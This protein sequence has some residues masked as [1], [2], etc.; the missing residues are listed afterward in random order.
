MTEQ[1]IIERLKELVEMG[2]SRRKIEM[3]L[4]MPINQLSGVM[5]GK[6]TFPAK[7]KSKLEFYITAARFA[8]DGFREQIEAVLNVPGIAETK[9]EAIS[10][11]IDKGVAIV[12]TTEEKTERIDP[13]SHQGEEIIDQARQ[14]QSKSFRTSKELDHLIRI[15]GD[16]DTLE[17][18]KC[19]LDFNEMVSS[20]NKRVFL[21]R[22]NFKLSRL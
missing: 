2:T 19:E 14:I 7:W 11:L 21:T 4:K 6:K 9:K 16:K 10:D 12:H 5:N 18:L 1:E 17:A 13:F 15:S 20:D 3:H 8:H 22:I